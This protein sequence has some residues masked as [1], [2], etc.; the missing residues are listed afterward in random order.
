[1]L[2]NLVIIGAMKCGTTSLHR[3]LDLHP[4]I[5]MSQT[6]ELD[7]F[8]EEKKWS[9]GLIW[10]E[11][12]FLQPDK[13][14]GESSPNYSKYPFFSGVPERMYKII[15]NT[16]LIYIIRDPIERIKSH[17]MHNIANG[18][19]KASLKQALVNLENNHYVNCSKYFMQL[20]KFYDYYSSSSILIVDLDDL[21]KN[22][23]KTL[24]RIFQFLGV[25]QFFENKEFT[26]IYHRSKN[27]TRQNW[28]NICT[29]Y[30]PGINKFKSMFPR[31][32]KHS[33]EKP[34]LGEELQKELIN[35]LK[36]DVEKL[37]AFTGCSFANWSL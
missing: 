37:K 6:K 36:Y 31:L 14:I 13:V 28:I 35:I 23:N 26:T 27:M 9:K 33:I 3:Y 19:E 7:F 4:D 17:Y 30:V 34:V 8:I 29:S 22:A 15:P 5:C 21:K 32:F 25:D 12:N 20:E 24:S 1:M 16:K 2:P 18:R 11:S 10:Y